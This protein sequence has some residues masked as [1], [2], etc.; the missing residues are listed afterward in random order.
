VKQIFHYLVKTATWDVTYEFTN[1]D[2]LSYTD[3]D[4]DDD[5]NSRKSTDVYLFLL[6][7]DSIN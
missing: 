3:T 4:W 6:F 2:L 5:Q 7:K 1:S